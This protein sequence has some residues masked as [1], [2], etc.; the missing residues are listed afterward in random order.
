MKRPDI[1]K[2]FKKEIQ[3]FYVMQQKK[4]NGLYSQWLAVRKFWKLS[5]LE[6]DCH[7]SKDLIKIRI[8][9]R[10]LKWAKINSRKLEPVNPAWV[11]WYKY[12]VIQVQIQIQMQFKYTTHTKSIK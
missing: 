8:E 2:W 6:K 11:P 7:F 3:N 12:S 10:K 1:K 5:A 9:Q 4:L